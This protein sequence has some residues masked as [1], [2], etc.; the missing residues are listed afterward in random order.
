MTPV[1]EFLLK[2]VSNIIISINNNKKANNEINIQAK[3]LKFD[4]II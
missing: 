2:W 3:S 4:T 1:L